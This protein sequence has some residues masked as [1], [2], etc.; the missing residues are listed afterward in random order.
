LRGPNYSEAVRIVAD[1]P[2]PDKKID[3]QQTE[4]PNGLTKS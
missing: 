4:Y 1:D 3:G 2:K